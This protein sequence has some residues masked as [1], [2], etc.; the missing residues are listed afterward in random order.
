MAYVSCATLDAKLALK[1][2]QLVTPSG[3]DLPGGSCVMTCAEVQAAIDNSGNVVAGDNVTVTGDGT[4]ATPYT[5]A[6]ATADTTVKGVVALAT[7]ADYPAFANDID[8]ATPAYV[9]A[10]TDA[11]APVGPDGTP[12]AGGDCVL[13]CPPSAGAAGDVLT[14]QPDGT[15]DWAPA[16]TGTPADG[17]ETKLSAG[18]NVTITGTGTAGSPYVINAAGGGTTADGSETKLTAGSGVTITGTGTAGDPYVITSAGGGTSYALVDCTGGAVASG[19]AVMTCVAGTAGQVLTK[20]ADGSHTWATLSGGGTPADGSETKLTAGT[21]VTITG[22]GTSADP[23]VVTASGG[24]AGL[25]LV[26]C[27]G[28]AIASGA[29]VMT[30]AAGGTAGQAL[31]KQADGSYAWNTLSGGGTPADGSETKLTAGTNVTITGTGTT[32]DPYVITSAGG[33]GGSTYVLKDCSGADL[34]SGAG[35]MPCPSNAGAAGEVLT[36]QADGSW[37]WAAAAAGGGGGG[38]WFKDKAGADVSSYVFFGAP[39]TTYCLKNTTGT[40]QTYTLVTDATGKSTAAPTASGTGA[41]MVL[42][43]IYQVYAADCSTFLG[44][45][46]GP[47]SA[48]PAGGGE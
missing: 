13:T 37:A 22:T 38:P 1:Q 21:G 3:G 19:A 33:G 48:A 10:A 17:S 32:A 36:K 46:D 44:W 30:C 23:Y 16:S 27:Q 20:Q 31:I 9:K 26:D 25:S 6:V 7:A 14:K 42:D 11:A 41:A 5:V 8:A 40:P 45:A 2:D 18:T 35:V 47:K 15:Y 12:V 4:I 39:N 34:A 43:S 28:A 24:G 29:A